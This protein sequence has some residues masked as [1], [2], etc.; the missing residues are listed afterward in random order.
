MFTSSWRYRRYHPSLLIGW[1]MAGVLL[2]VW[3]GRYAGGLGWWTLAPA[4]LLP[5]VRGRRWWAVLAVVLIGGAIGYAR[6][7][8][9]SHQ[10]SQYRYYMGRTVQLQGIISDDPQY[11]RQGDQRFRVG[12][13]RLDGQALP[14]EVAAGTFSIADVRRGD[15]VTM[16]GKLSQGYGSYQAGLRYATLSGWQSRPDAVRELRDRFAA[17]VRNVI[18]EPMASLGVGF[19]VGQRSALP[20]GLDDQM[21]AIGLTHI[22]V[23]SGYNLTILVRFARRLFERHSLYLATAVAATMMLVFVL[24]SGLSPSMSRAALVTGLSLAAWYYGRAF[25]PLVLIALTAGITALVYPVYVWS[26]IGWYLSFLAFTGVLVVAPLLMRLV[27]RGKQAGPVSQ[28]VLET[29]AAQL[30]TAPIILFIFGTEPPLALL[31]NVLVAPTIPLAMLLTTVAGVGGMLAPHLLGMLGAPAQFVLA[32]VV[33]I[34]QWLAGFGLS[35]QLVV[36]SWQMLALYGLVA[37]GVWLTA[38]KLRYNFRQT[39]IVE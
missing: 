38:K 27:Y 39:S 23:A 32:Y 25:H 1:A 17:G 8:G 6:G 29:M 16:S 15:A 4:C 24:V 10:I 31:A 7:E 26:D 14:G 21:R 33:A 22:V 9:F 37:V 34:V 36:S 18:G 19:V 30:M 35:Y 20:Q 3:L 11:G 28:I 5:L 13:V 12:Q 2:G